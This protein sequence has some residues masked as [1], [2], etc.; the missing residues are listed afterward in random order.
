MI[1]HL[2]EDELLEA[3]R[4]ARPALPEEE[5]SPA[6]AQA[7]A[8][9]QR[10][11]AS[12]QRPGRRIFRRA[13]GA[14][15]VLVAIGATLL[16]VAVAI[17]TLRSHVPSAAG[18]SSS[19]RGEIV[20]RNGRVLAESTTQLTSVQIIRSRLPQSRSARE[21]ELRTPLTRSEGRAPAAGGRIGNS[22][23]LAIRPPGRPSGRELRGSP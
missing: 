21:A 18:G 5:L 1:D 15:P 23:D 8:V 12:R 2:L 9:L 16:V 7:R 19:I 6:G 11:H 10:V 22:H 3:V 14:V 20:D 13:M 17:A 4:S